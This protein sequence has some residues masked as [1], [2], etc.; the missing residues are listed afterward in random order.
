MLL[1]VAFFNDILLSRHSP[2]R[3]GQAHLTAR[4]EFYGPDS[5]ILDHGR[6]AKA[7]DRSAHVWGYKKVW[8]SVVPITPFRSWFVAQYVQEVS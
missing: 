7:Y 5:N 6:V 4:D 2:A 1:T 8:S 3:C